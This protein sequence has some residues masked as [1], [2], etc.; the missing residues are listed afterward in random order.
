M[1]ATQVVYARKTL[2]R[3][4]PTLWNRK[5]QIS[6]DWQAWG[7][8][9]AGLLVMAV[10]LFVYNS[11]SASQSISRLQQVVVPGLFKITFQ[12]VRTS[13]SKPRRLKWAACYRV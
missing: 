9:L 4:R 8:P 11:E 3:R 6:N 10:A 13:N 7:R 1:A 5:W 12:G 2:K